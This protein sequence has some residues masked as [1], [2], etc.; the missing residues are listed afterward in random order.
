LGDF[1]NELS[2]WYL[3]RSRDRFKAGDQEGVNVLGFV[4]IELSKIMAPFLPFTAE[5]IYRQVSDQ[6]ESVHL[7]AWPK[8]N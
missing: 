2:T 3:R 8:V 1:I 5:D 4:L 6:L 7:E